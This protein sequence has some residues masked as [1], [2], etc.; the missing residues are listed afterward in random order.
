[1]SW[2]DANEKNCWVMRENKQRP[3]IVF[4]WCFFDFSARKKRVMRKKIPVFMCFS[5]ILNTK[6]FKINKKKEVILLSELVALSA[7]F[8]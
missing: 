4:V 6:N 1:M 3:K 7:A 5:D 2:R 8:C